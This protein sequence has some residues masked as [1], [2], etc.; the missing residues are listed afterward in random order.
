MR[1]RGGTI[2]VMILLVGVLAGCGRKLEVAQGTQPTGDAFTSALHSYYTQRSAD[3]WNE[4][5]YRDSDY[6]AKKAIAAAGG[7]NVLPTEVDARKI[8]PEFAGE[9]SEAR[10]ILIEALDGGG[11]TKVPD[12]AAKAQTSFDCWMQEQEENRQP[13]DIA[14]CKNDFWM[15]MNALQEALKPMAEAEPEPEPAPAPMPEPEAATFKIFRQNANARSSCSSTSISRTFV[16][17]K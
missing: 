2:L 6:F 17:T 5:D 1:L 10:R 15:A 4:G 9:L 7:E 16:T 12:L 11:R 13:E 14:G 3:E 8:G